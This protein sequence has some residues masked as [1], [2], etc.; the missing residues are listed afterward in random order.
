MNMKMKVQQAQQGRIFARVKGW[1]CWPPLEGERLGGP[2]YLL[3]NWSLD[4][5]YG[6]YRI[7]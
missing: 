5:G 6:A 4:D 7:K 3:C 2:E 1:E